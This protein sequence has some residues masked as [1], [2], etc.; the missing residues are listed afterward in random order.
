M[1]MTLCKWHEIS[2]ALSELYLDLCLCSMADKPFY[3]A[4][5]SLSAE[6]SSSGSQKTFISKQD[7]A[8]I[9]QIQCQ[10]QT[11][12]E[13]EVG[14]QTLELPCYQCSHDFYSSGRRRCWQDSTSVLQRGRIQSALTSIPR[15][16]DYIQPNFFQSPQ[17]TMSP[18]AEMHQKVTKRLSFKSSLSGISEGNA[19]CTY[20][21]VVG[22][23]FEM[24]SL[25]IYAGKGRACPSP[26]EKKKRKRH[27]C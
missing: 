13:K 2:L 18:G 4:A 8:K 12:S 23:D 6:L 14:Q 22:E 3:P 1:K 19:R 21:I 25:Q 20:S 10:K 15:S 11:S 16:S 26:E 27:F 5:D 24:C 9:D 7:K 17:I